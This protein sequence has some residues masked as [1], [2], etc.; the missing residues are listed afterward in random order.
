VP[1]AALVSHAQPA[2]PPSHHGTTLL[3]LGAS[4]APVLGVYG[5]DVPSHAHVGASLAA[6]SAAVVLANWLQPLN[7]L[8]PPSATTR[9]R[10]MWSL[11]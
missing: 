2:T 8:Q 1:R 10:M 9:L 3:R 4:R 6:A 5:V 7:L 11:V